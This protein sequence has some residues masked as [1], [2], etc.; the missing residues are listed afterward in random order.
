M[1][2]KQAEAELLIY[3]CT[4]LSG[5]GIPFHRNRVIENIYENEKKKAM[6]VIKTL[7]EDLQ[8][9]FLK[10]FNQLK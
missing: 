5:S 4:K 3:F 10:E 6:K 7:H 1:G 9:D 8:Y 2:S